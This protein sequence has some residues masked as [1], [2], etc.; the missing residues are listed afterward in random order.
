MRSVVSVNGPPLTKVSVLSIETG[1][2][3]VVL[4]TRNF[5][6]INSP[7][8]R[9]IGIVLLNVSWTDALD[10]IPMLSALG[11]ATNPSRPAKVAES[12]SVPVVI[13]LPA[14]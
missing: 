12:D 7:V 4:V 11:V 14:K 5:T 13:V 2:P 9:M 8:P 10:E 1:V 3:S 6:S